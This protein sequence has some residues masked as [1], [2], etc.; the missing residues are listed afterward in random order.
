MRVI[1]WLIMLFS[2]LFVNAQVDY[3]SEW[4]DLFSYNQVLALDKSPSSFY[5]LT[6]NAVFSYDY[7]SSEIQKIS[8]VN[9]LSGGNT[10]AINYD[11]VNQMLAIGYETGL[12]ELVTSNGSVKKVVDIEISDISLQKGVNKIVSYDDNLLLALE[13]GIVVYD[14]LNLEFGDT[15]FIGENSTAVDVT[16]ILI[17]NNEI[18]A[19]STDGYYIANLQDNLNDSKSWV[20][21]SSGEF[22]SLTL[23]KDVV[24]V[25]KGR[26]FYEVLNDNSLGSIIVLTSNI[27]DVSADVETL[28]LLTSKQ[29]FVYDNNFEF[30]VSSDSS[31]NSLSSAILSQDNVYLGSLGS[32]IL[33]SLLSNINNFDEILPDGPSSNNLFSISVQ[34]NKLWCVYGGIQPW[35]APLGRTKGIS[36]FDGNK[37]SEIKYGD[38]N[39]VDKARDLLHV[40]VNPEDS[41]KVYVS[42]WAQ[43]SGDVDSTDGGGVL[44]LENNNFSEF[45]NAVNTKIGDNP[46]LSNI[47]IPGDPTYTSTRIYG[48]VFDEEGNIWIANSGV[49]NGYGFLKK[50]TKEGVWTSHAAENQGKEYTHLEIDLQGNIWAGS[51]NTGLHVYNESLSEKISMV[52]ESQGIPNDNVR[53]LA[54][55]LDNN[56]WI[57]TASGLVLFSDVDNVFESDVVYP[58]AVI[59]DGADGASKLLD[60]LVINDIKVDGA[61]NVW[62]ATGSGG[63]LQTDA[64]GKNTL[65]GFNIDNSPLPS[66]N[67]LSIGID[68]ESG[69]VY[70]GTQNGIVSYNAGV[71]GYGDELTDVYAYPNPVLKNHSK[72][73]I[74]GKGSNLPEGTNIKILDVAG[75]LVYESNALA[76]QS[77]YGGKFVWDKRNLAGAKVASGVYIVLL[78][79]ADGQQT[80]STKI[81]IVN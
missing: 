61:G 37:W 41:N 24:Y 71:I 58:E 52:G 32:G 45:W 70:F 78:Y 5:A 51:R 9:G 18:Y 43:K 60:G 76:E 7:G 15:Y 62:F 16:D 17:H 80:S 3:T 66:N 19:T 54:V 69:E 57:G 35:Y 63:V 50:R 53:C 28:L 72:V 75:S 73:T 56:V 22:S 36:H 33:S 47:T 31:S 10:S 8:S 1:C 59:I 81:A 67:V 30:I 21:Y 25:V 2:V 29:A 13:F 74:V 6:E 11:E 55:G 4:R 48:T 49:S 26:T 65:R 77:E 40:T 46:G 68:H 12:L 27:V 14:L 34:G 23:F 64:T 20:K 39:G 44:V 38:P 42:S 79:N